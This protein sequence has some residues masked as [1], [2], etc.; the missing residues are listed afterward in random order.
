MA[1][2][3][4]S[5]DRCRGVER[6]ATGTIGTVSSLL[7]LTADL[8]EVTYAPGEVVIEQGTRTGGIWILVSGAVDVRRGD[9]HISTVDHAG[10]CFGDISILLDQPHG[11]TV[12]AAGTTVMRH[13]VDG[14]ALFDQEAGFARFVAGSL[15]RRLDALTIYLADLQ[16]QYGTAP[17]L[18]M[19]ADVLRHISQQPVEGAR[20][21]SSRDPDPGF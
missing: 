17:G 9:Q 11:A 2:R 21:V 8:P 7:T 1:V 10:A 5:G 13:A 15:A 14:A 20:P 12:V 16:R 18:S 4:C 19:V 6:A 3:G